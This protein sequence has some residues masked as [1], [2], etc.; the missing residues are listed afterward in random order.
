MSRTKKGRK[1]PGQEYW[2]ARPGNKFGGTPGADTK[3][4]THKVERQEGKREATAAQFEP[5]YTVSCEACE[6]TPTIDIFVEG[7]LE[8]RT[9]MCGPCTWGEAATIDPENW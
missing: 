5:N 4:R 6:Q 8:R 7:K 2:T 9:E 1:A 3:H